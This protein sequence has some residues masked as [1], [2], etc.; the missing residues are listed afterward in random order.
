MPAAHKPTKETRETVKLYCIAGFGHKRIAERLGISSN[1]LAKYYPK[2]LK[3]AK[4]DTTKLAI[5]T[6][7]KAMRNGSVAA[8]KFWLNCKA[9]F[10]AARENKTVGDLTITVKY[11]DE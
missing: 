10:V 8:A 11:V 9:G 6:L 7:N 3:D 4:D 5:T 2:E 1:T